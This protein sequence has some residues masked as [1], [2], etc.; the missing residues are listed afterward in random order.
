MLNDIFCELKETYRYRYVVYN[1]VYTGLKVRYKRS[2]LGYLWTVL[3]PMAYYF[4]LAFIFSY[5]LRAVRPGSNFYVYMFSGAVIFS[6]ISSIINQSCRIMF[7]NE[8]YIKKIYVPKFVFIL[9]VV[10][11]ELTNFLLILISILILGFVSHQISFS[12]IYFFSFIPVLL[13]VFFASGIAIIMSIATVY[14]RDLS[15]IIPVVMNACFFGTPIMYYKELA[16]PVL[17]QLNYF[18]PLF[19]FVELFRTPFLL[20]QLPDMKLLAICTAF[21]FLTFFSG[22]YL[23]TKFNNRIIFKL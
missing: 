12:Y 13:A 11:Y 20:N 18:N 17:I 3:A 10:F 19:Y 4:T 2:V 1:F 16:P 5:G 14:F 9:N 23:L 8:S 15:E 22:L 6:A 7:N 21:T